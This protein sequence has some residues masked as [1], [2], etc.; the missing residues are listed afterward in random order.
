M[1]AADAGG[2]HQLV[3]VL[4]YT[5]HSHAVGG[6]SHERPGTHELNIAAG[7]LEGA[8]GN[9][10]IG[11]GP[12]VEGPGADHTVLGG[13]GGG[14][15]GLDGLGSAG[16]DAGLTGG[17]VGGSG[18]GLTIHAVGDLVGGAVITQ[19]KS[20]GGI[21]NTGVTVSIAV[22]VDEESAV[23]LSNFIG[24]GN[25]I[26]AQYGTQGN[27]SGVILHAVGVV[28]GGHIVVDTIGCKGPG[29]DKF[30]IT[31][32]HLEGA[33][34]NGGVGSGPAVEDP[35]ANHI[36]L[37]G[38]GGGQAT[39][40]GLG[41]TS[42]DA[43]LN[44]G[45]G[46]G[47]GGRLTL[48][49][50]GDV[51]QGSGH[52]GPGADE[53]NVIA[54]HLESAIGNSNIGSGPAIEGPGADHAVLGGLGGGQAILHGLGLA[55][56]DTGLAG[57]NG[58]GSGGRLTLHAVGD[59]IGKAV[60]AQGVNGAVLGDAAVGIGQA[61][62]LTVGGTV[63]GGNFSGGGQ[64]QH[65][66]HNV[67]IAGGI[68][69]IIGVVFGDHSVA[70]GGGGHEGPS[71]HELH[72]VTGHLETTVLDGSIGS[73]P[74]VEDPGADHGALSG[75][76]GGQAALHGLGSAGQDTGLAGGNSGRSGGRL[77]L[78]AVG[79]VI[80]GVR[81]L[82]VHIGNYLVRI[83]GTGSGI[84]LGT[85]ERVTLNRLLLGSISSAFQLVVLNDLVS[86]NIA[87]LIHVVD[88][89]IK[90]N[91][92]RSVGVGKH[93]CLV[94]GQGEAVAGH[95]A[96]PINGGGQGIALDRRSTF[97]DH[98]VGL[99][100]IQNGGADGAGS[101]GSHGDLNGVNLGGAIVHIEGKGHG[102]GQSDAFH[103]LLNGKGGL[104]AAG[105]RAGT[106]LEVHAAA[107]KLALLP[108]ALIAGTL[109][110]GLT[111]IVSRP[112]LNRALKGHGNDDSLSADIK[113]DVLGQADG[114]VHGVVGGAHGEGAVKAALTLIIDLRAANAEGSSSADLQSSGGIVFLRQFHIS[115]IG[116]AIQNV[117]GSQS[118]VNVQMESGIIVLHQFPLGLSTAVGTV[119]MLLFA[120]APAK[121][122]VLMLF[123]A[124]VVYGLLE[125]P[126][127]ERGDH[128][129]GLGVLVCGVNDVTHIIGV[130]G[131]TLSK[132]GAHHAD[133]HHD[134]QQ[135]GKGSASKGFPIHLCCHNF[136]L[137]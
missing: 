89:Q 2:L 36:A 41:D 74:A 62:I 23:N 47:S 69:L 121:K 44:S 11:S 93:N 91:G 79:D 12:A 64:G 122:A 100:Q 10:N 72:I 88:G 43:G 113:A 30:H 52:K 6:G 55:G 111:D 130:A 22:V 39:L 116:H 129:G 114:V 86:D 66:V 98:V 7:H 137:L 134:S 49:T 3:A 15:A 14:Q 77:T 81:V 132:C 16:R 57:G 109:H 83:H 102:F 97:L 105:G 26:D 33:V 106:Q 31:S 95:A 126:L 119:R 135:D 101:S 34:L 125:F 76:G 37:G 29:T 61:V 56:Q 24:G 35:G 75:L 8:V 28:F 90:V 48:H 110:D 120:A 104:G 70:V 67:Q 123:H 84:A 115:S 9:G 25:H 78:H 5:V 108:L 73:S 59:V 124:A 46:G 117:G 80:G 85:L 63:L 127:G 103:I 40:H 87:G 118:N 45:N 32:R 4:V 96:L 19:D 42:L 58:G 131:S 21:G 136:N 51:V 60:I 38:L 99:V 17:N 50:V 13:L 92:I 94:A 53:L 112:E 18:R 71:A 1:Q 68:Q 107:N 65:A 128:T 27:Q 20:I 82:A 133:D 54:G